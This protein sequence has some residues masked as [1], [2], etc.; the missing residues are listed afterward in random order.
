MLTRLG[1]AVLIATG[2]LVAAG[3]PGWAD[4]TAS[5]TCHG[6]GCTVS[7]RSSFA[8]PGRPAHGGGGHG[9][10]GGGLGAFTRL[11]ARQSVSC[12]ALGPLLANACVGA[13]LAGDFASGRP[14]S[15][16]QRSVSP[17]RLARRAVSR[18]HLPRPVIHSSPPADRQLVGLASWLWISAGVWRE[19]SA[20]ASVP[21][22]S[23]E[24][25]ARPVS[26]TWRM[27]D[28]SRLMCRGPGTPW[29][30]GSDS[31]SGSSPTCGHTYNHAGVHR[32]VATITWAIGWNGGGS[33]G[34]L[35]PMTTSSAVRMRVG[36]SQAIVRS[37]GVR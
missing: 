20:R 28:G 32:A 3:A 26:V 25:T 19:R 29:R 10:G 35:P 15:A 30:A 33:S 31:P 13:E 36:E 2:V 7:A 5:I 9:R 8:R 17:A 12:Q 24:A 4:G 22:T 34:S 37:G 21:G 1:C 14:R 6:A 27:G 18:L 16:R 11:F 23:V